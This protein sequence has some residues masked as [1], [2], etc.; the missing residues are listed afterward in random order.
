MIWFII[1]VLLICVVMAFGYLYYK[2]M[3]K[4]SFNERQG[5]YCVT[6]NDKTFAQCL[7]CADCG[8]CMNDFSAYCT[9][10]DSHGPYSGTCK[11]W[12]HNDPFTRAVLSNDNDYIE[13]TSKII[14]S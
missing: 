2:Y 14:D 12:Y 3:S 7:E 9:K 4:E 5:S 13:N 11:K 1:I 10:G 8:Y 6:C